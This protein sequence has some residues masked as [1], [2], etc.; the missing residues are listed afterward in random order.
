MNESHVSTHPELENTGRDADVV[1][2]CVAEA[3]A[4]LCPAGRP[5]R[6]NAV[7]SGARSEAL[8]EVLAPAKAALVAQVCADLGLDTDDAPAV[9]R[10]LVDAYVEASLLRESQFALLVT[11]GGPVTGK[12]KMRVHLSAWATAVDRESRLAQAIGIERK[13]RKV[14]SLAEALNA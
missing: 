4:R 10:R 13:A 8:W 1:A 11:L 2:A 7:K 3:T 6:L 12:G 9:K 14:Q 5:P